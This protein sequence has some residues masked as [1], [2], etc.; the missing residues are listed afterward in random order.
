MHRI[1]VDYLGVG[2]LENRSPLKIVVHGIVVTLTAIG[3]TLFVPGLVA[4]K[5]RVFNDA[6]VQARLP[7]S[8]GHSLQAYIIRRD[9]LNNSIISLRENLDSIHDPAQQK[10]FD[11][12]VHLMEERRQELTNLQPPIF[13]AGFFL[14]PQMLLWPAI[15]TSLGC[16]L[17]CFPNSKKKPFRLKRILQNL[18]LGA[19]I[20]FFYEW[21]LWTRNFLLGSNGR[22]VYAYSNYDIDPKSFF[23]QELMI[24]G[25]AVLIAAVWLRWS[26][27]TI[28]A[29]RMDAAAIESQLDYLSPQFVVRLQDAFSNWIVSSV[30]LGLGFVYFTTFFWSLVA[31]YHDERYIVSAFLAHSLWAL[32][33][34]F[35]SMP[36]ITL[37]K[38]LKT[39][40]L[41]AIEHLIRMSQVTPGKSEQLNLEGLEKLESLAGIRISIAGVGAVVSL[42]L[43]LLQ[44]VFHK[45]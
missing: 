15:Y 8:A 26:D 28:D 35:L 14:S 10:D 44:L 21:P 23:A 4:V 25:F 41:I 27:F 38:S 33:W 16:L 17:F 34:V 45:S 9:S 42:I 5:D 20:Y 3:L 22:T 39:R 6:D 19:L 7:A 24:A 40:R 37:W 12:Y 1:L 43:P 30:V 2:F 29:T 31:K 32:T 18:W 11:F 36:V 13:A